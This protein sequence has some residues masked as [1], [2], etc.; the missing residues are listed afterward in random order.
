MMRNVTPA[1]AALMYIDRK[2]SNEF[3]S[4]GQI[5]TRGIGRSVFWRALLPRVHRAPFGYLCDNAK[6]NMHIYGIL[7][8][9]QL[10]HMAGGHTAV[11][12]YVWSI[13]CETL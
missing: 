12:P 7:R 11:M 13:R 2:S 3:T 5:G 1:P 8:T 6:N 9:P 10:W 4:S